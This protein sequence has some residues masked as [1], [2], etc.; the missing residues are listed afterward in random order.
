MT[1]TKMK[2]LKVHVRA[3]QVCC[4]MHG[5]THRMSGVRSQ[6]AVNVKHNWT[7]YVHA[8]V[9]SL[10]NLFFKTLMK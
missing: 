5:V 1:T 3:G 9:F 2:T 6:G 4:M 7:I 10:L 8:A